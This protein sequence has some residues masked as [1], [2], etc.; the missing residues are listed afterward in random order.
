MWRLA[1]EPQCKSIAE[2]RVDGV[3]RCRNH[4]GKLA[5]DFLINAGSSVKEKQPLSVSAPTVERLMSADKDQIVFELAF[6]RVALKR[7]H[8]LLAQTGDEQVEL[9]IM[10]LI[11]ETEER[12][13]DLEARRFDSESR[14]EDR[15][16]RG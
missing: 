15:R 12:I 6:L 16:R 8:T 7:Y 9:I 3:P 14:Q 10:R 11:M 1:E 5:I 2:Y 13:A 4:A